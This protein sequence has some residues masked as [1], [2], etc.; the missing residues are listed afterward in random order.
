MK[1]KHITA[2]AALAAALCLAWQGAALAADTGKIKKC[3]D[4]QGRWHYGDRADEECA[5]SRITEINQRGIPVRE[6]AAPLTPEQIREREQQKQGQQEEQKRAE[7]QARRDRVLLATYGSEDDITQTRDR[8]I[9]EIDVQIRASE[10]TLKALHAALAR[11]QQQ[12]AT[13][14][15]GGGKPAAATAAG[16]TK[17]EGQIAKQ[18]VFIKGKHDEQDAIRRRFEADLARFRQLT[19]RG[20]DTTGNHGK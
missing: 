9:A 10:D 2:L 15:R 3:Q 11:Y 12:A 7:E 4:A 8:K 17:T 14:G 20:S 5:Q 18:E 19:N 16:I 6:I 13:E 1:P